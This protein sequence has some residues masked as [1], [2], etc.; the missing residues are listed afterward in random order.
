MAKVLRYKKKGDISYHAGD[1]GTYQFFG[2][3]NSVNKGMEL[4]MNEDHAKELLA[5]HPNELEE[6]PHEKWL[7]HHKTKAEKHAAARIADA[8]KA[9]PDLV[10]DKI[11]PKPKD[12]EA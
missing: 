7:P 4:F 6:V 8:A 12:K 9:F 11:L 1:G 10:K 3:E 5:A 2:N